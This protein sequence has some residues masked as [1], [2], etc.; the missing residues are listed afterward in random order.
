MR[1]LVKIAVPF[2]GLYLLLVAALYTAMWW[3]PVEFAGLIA[4]FPAV[5]PAVMPFRLM[6]TH[7][8]SGDIRPGDGA[9]DFEL[10][11]YDKKSTVQ[12]SGLRGRPVVLIF[13]SYT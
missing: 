2:G 1:T 10:S 3:P 4:K 12:L 11:T 5:T 7:A 6:W 8:R 13:G 9:P